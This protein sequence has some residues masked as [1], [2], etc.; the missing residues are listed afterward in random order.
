[1]S[2]SLRLEEIDARARKRIVL[3]AAA[4]LACSRWRRRRH[5]DRVVVVCTEETPGIQLRAAFAESMRRDGLLA[6]A[7]EVLSRR[8]PPD[9]VLLY[10][11]LD[12]EEI[13]GTALWTLPL[14]A[15]LARLNES[16]EAST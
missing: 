13:S 7:H 16:A 2:G 10:L 6:F 9:H 15:E 4:A 3:A 5:W 11:V 14:C 1:M 12:R 8:L